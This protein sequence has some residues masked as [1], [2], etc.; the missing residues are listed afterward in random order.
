MLTKIDKLESLYET[1]KIDFNLIRYVPGLA[2]IAYLGQIYLL[3]AKGKH[4]SETCSQKK[5]SRI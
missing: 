2:N 3:Q 5:Q 4:A 1:G